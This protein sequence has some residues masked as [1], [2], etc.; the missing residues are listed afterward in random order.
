MP[1]ATS[2]AFAHDWPDTVRLVTV[3]GAPH[4]G[5]WNAD[6][7]AYAYAYAKELAAF[8]AQHT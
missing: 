1:Y 6:A 8:L 2:A 4:T 7:Y 5:A 3:E